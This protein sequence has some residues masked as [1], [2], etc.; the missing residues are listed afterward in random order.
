MFLWQNLRIGDFPLPCLI[1]G[2][3]WLQHLLYKD[4]CATRCWNRKARVAVKQVWTGLECAQLRWSHVEWDESVRCHQIQW[5][6][7]TAVTEGDRFKAMSHWERMIWHGLK[8]MTEPSACGCRNHWT[9]WDP[10]YRRRNGCFKASNASLGR[11]FGFLGLRWPRILDMVIKRLI[12][13]PIHFKA[14]I[15]RLSAS[16]RGPQV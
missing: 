7:V 16:E 8:P 6:G 3:Y 12:H 5:S 10:T 11:F 13:S 9:G 15:C 1:A 14:F 4:Y 2:E